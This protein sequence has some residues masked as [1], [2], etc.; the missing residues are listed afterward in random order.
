MNIEIV[1]K[2]IN[3]DNIE[4]GTL[5]KFSDKGCYFSS[6]GILVKDVDD[7]N[8][9]LYDIESDKY[10]TDVEMYDITVV[11]NRKVKLVIE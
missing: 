6:Y 8:P 9:I 7:Q 1:D 10:Y 2:E 3:F 5:V 4:S 11:Q